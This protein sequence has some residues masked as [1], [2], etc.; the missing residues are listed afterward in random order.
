MSAH[1]GQ[2]T[3]LWSRAACWLGTVLPNL[4]RAAREV[5]LCRQTVPKTWRQIALCLWWSVSHE[6]LQVEEGTLAA[7][8]CYEWASTVRSRRSAL[9]FSERVPALALVLVLVLVLCVGWRSGI[10]G[11]PFPCVPCSPPWQHACHVR[12]LC[13]SHPPVAPCSHVAVSAEASARYRPPAPCEGQQ[14]GAAAVGR[15]AGC[16]CEVCAC[17]V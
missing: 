13:L 2:G 8:V 3:L 12:A 10:H 4:P 7:S 17:M 6:H 16:W 9:A 15:E 1:L 5:P 14:R 11:V